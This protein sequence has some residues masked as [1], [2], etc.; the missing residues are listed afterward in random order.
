MM[1]LA[2]V[3]GGG[4]HVRVEATRPKMQCVAS[5][6]TSSELPGLTRRW[7][8]PRQLR[9]AGQAAHEGRVVGVEEEAVSQERG[10]RQRE[11]VD[12]GRLHQGLQLGVREG[13]QDVGARA[14]QRRAAGHQ[15]FQR[16]SSDD[17]RSIRLAGGRPS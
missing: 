8:G 13:V 2:Q 4:P 11:G 3:A 6:Q 12:R 14:G 17:E 1:G 9:L 5:F 7:D 16:Q 10:D 15:L